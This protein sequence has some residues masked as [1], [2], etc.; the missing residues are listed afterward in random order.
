MPEI[1]LKNVRKVYSGGVYALDGVNLNLEQG[2]FLSVVG[3]SGC[4]KTTLLKCIAGLEP[5]TAG[6]LFISGEITNLTRVQ[7]R[8][9]GIVFQEFTLYPNMSVFENIAFALKKQKMPYDEMVQRVRDIMEKMDLM[10]ISAQIP[11]ELSYG[12]KQK[13]SLARALVKHPDIILFDEPLSNIDEMLKREYRQFIVRTKELFPNSTYIYV[14]HNLHEALSMGNKLLVMDKGKVVQYGA[15]R[16]LFEYPCNRVI[17]EALHQDVKYSDC[18]IEKGFIV[19]DEEKIELSSLQKASLSTEANVAAVCAQYDGYVSCFDSEGNAIIGVPDRVSF[20]MEVEDDT[21]SICDKSFLVEP[22]SE[23]LLSKGR[24]TAVLAQRNFSV[25]YVPDSVELEGIVRFCDREYICVEIG[26]TKVILPKEENG[27]EK[28]YVGDRVSLYYPIMELELYDEAGNQM[29]SQYALNDNVIEANV[30]SAQK[31]I[32]KIGNRKLK[33]ERVLPKKTVKL[34]F[35][36]DAFSLTSDEKKGL[37]I[38]VLNEEFCNGQTIVHA[39]IKGGQNYLTMIFE[40]RVRCLGNY[41]NY[42]TV[43]LEKVTVVE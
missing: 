23:G 31:G 4:G 5:I 9:V 13:V 43:N 14:T 12:Q 41:R 3:A 32:V 24:G 22:I 27:E 16:Q 17:L 36:R 28:L 26:K 6:E 29:L 35:K 42:V 11:K 25:S 33:L 10:D 8:K 38:F 15:V 34:C 37:E 21:I 1:Q 2:D 20:P 40:G 18:A 7:E 39:E 30:V 19:T